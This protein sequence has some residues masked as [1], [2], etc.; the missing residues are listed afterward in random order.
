MH[1]SRT[2]SRYRY[3]LSLLVAVVFVLYGCASSSSTSGGG[4]G[5]GGNT[6]P[7]EIT[8]SSLPSGSVSTAYSAALAATGGTAPYT[9]A[10]T[11][12]TLPAGLNLAATGSITGTP[13][14]TAAAVPL[15]FKVTDSSS[16]PQTATVSLTI[17]ITAASTTLNVTTTALPNGQINTA[18]STTLAAAGGTAP[19]TWSL[20]TGTLPTGLTLNASTGVISGTPTA[21]ANAT[22]LTFKVTDSSNPVQT[23]TKGLTLT[24]TGSATLAVTTTSLPAGQ[25]GVVYSAALTAT[26]GTTPYSWQITSG[27]LPNGLSLSSTGAITGTPAAGTQVNAT[28]LT[29]KVTDS[30]NPA[31]T[32]SAN[33]TLTITAATLTITTT[34]IPT[35]IVNQAYTTT[36][37]AIGGTAPYSWTL[38]NGTSLPAGLSLS[39]GGVISGTPTATATNASFTVKATDS[40][41]P[42]AQTATANLTITITPSGITITTTSLPNGSVDNAYTTTLAAT[43]GTTPYTWAVTSGTLPGGLNLNPASGVISGTP[44]TAITATPLT[45]TVTDST[46]PTSL[47]Q[48]VNLTLTIN[49]PTATITITNTTLPNGAINTAYN[50]TLNATGGVA[51]YT[52][53]LT[54]GTLPAGMNFNTTT[55]VIGGTPTVTASNVP[56]TFKVTDSTTP[57]KLT[58]TA[59][60][61][62]TIA[63]AGSITVSVSPVRAAATTTQVLPVTATTNDSS[64][65][66]WSS[67]GGSFSTTTSLTGVSVNFTAPSTAGSYT[68][69]ATSVTDNT[70]TATAT[71]YVTNLAGVYTYHND[72][73]RDGVNNQEYALNTSNVNTSTFGK[74]FSCAA[75]GAIYAQPLWVANVSI[76]GGTHNVIIAATMRDSV[77]AFDAD[78]NPCVTYWHKTLIPSGETYGNYLDTGSEDIYPDIGILGTPVIDP[79]S[80]KIYLITKTKT[81]S[82]G[83]YHQRLH[84]L[85]IADGSEPVT[86]V[87]LTNGITVSGSGD[88]GDSSCPSSSGSVPF[89]P[90]RLN[91]RPGLALYN[92]VVYASWASHG[93]EQ[94]YHG[95]ILGFN[96]STLAR[97][98]TYNTSPNGR[99]A[100]IWMSGGAPAFDSSGNMYVITG[101]GDYNGTSDFGDSLLKLSTSGGLS[102]G[103]STS[104]P[105]AGTCWFTPYNQSSL[106]AADAD[107][108]AGA[109]VVLVDLP[110]GAPFQHLV[111]GGGKG[112]GFSGELYILNRDDLGGYTGPNGPNNSV[113]EFSFGNPIFSTPV[114]WQNHIYVAGVSGALK[115]F[116]VSNTANPPVNQTPTS[117]SSHT[118]GFPGAT[119]SLS[120]LGTSNGVI[121]AIDNSSYGTS[122]GGSKAAGPAV[123]HAYDVTALGSEL[124]NSSTVAG[125]AAGNAV[126]FTVPTVA[127]GHVY[128]GT[129]GNDTT[130]GSGS[131]FGE[132]D[133][134][135]LKPN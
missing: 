5:G 95:W 132:V 117:Q 56:L 35:G 2:D 111:I 20:Q 83:T 50:T 33:L 90:L 89:C 126:K 59:N 127:N 32:A 49:P 98:V 6:S 65:V 87:D 51:P 115:A 9:W 7:L 86:A 106:D 81:T 62:L 31:Q 70:K 60:F 28:P 72:L 10:I 36:L 118:F 52:W 73:S 38:A 3:A 92:G 109:A 4:G 104:N 15:S 48:T 24:I 122:N 94:P 43:G 11:S 135:G 103:C 45:F 77:Y 18:Y 55:G 130:Q 112:S 79:S 54:S 102:L 64:G 30:G 124:W 42:T 53:A 13:T 91:Q 96:A 129:R 66:N 116:S 58:Q 128:I 16:T 40:G 12:G 82:A 133:V 100:G 34:S 57:T 47:K 119:P 1:S 110:S 105:S 22:P 113:Q 97:T 23:A 67:S 78:A 44:T 37:G 21:N 84:V 74:L 8:T 107:F 14:A 131:V 29:V 93:D 25:V 17:T 68:V 88:T 26:G 108:G 27:T 71:I 80:N 39:T 121:W 99:E 19:Y 114:Y 76:G 85:N 61:T 75:D 123:L 46:T 120:S 101:N 41:S 134:Y 63:S 69:T 125:D